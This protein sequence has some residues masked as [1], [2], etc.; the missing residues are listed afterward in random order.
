MEERNENQITEQE[1]TSVAEA[2]VITEA[3]EKQEKKKVKKIVYVSCNPATLAKNI[4]H[5]QKDYV[6]KYVQPLDMFPNTAN[7]ECVVCLVRK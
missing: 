2:S 4:N 1:A 3:N 6:V 5:L 7:V